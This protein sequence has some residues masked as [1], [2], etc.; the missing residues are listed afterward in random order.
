MTQRHLVDLPMTD[1]RRSKSEL[2]LRNVLDLPFPSDLQ[3]APRG[4]LVAW[5][6]NESGC[7][8]VW[9][10]DAGHIEAVAARR[11]TTYSGDDGRTIGQLRWNR[12]CDAVIYVRGTHL[13][14]G[15]P[16]NPASTPVGAESSEIWLAHLDGEPSRRLGAG[17][18]PEVSH[19]TGDVA[20]IHGT[21]I[22]IA[23]ELGQRQAS[24][25][26]VDRGLCSSLAWSP[27]GTCLAFVSDRG[28]HSL[29]GVHDVA[30]RI[31]RWIAPG[32]DR[33]ILPTW[34]P[35]GKRLAFVRLAESPAPTWRSRPCGI[36][37]SLWIANAHTG[38]AKC[39]WTASEGRGSVFT[40][41]AHGPSLAWTPSGELAF[42]WEGSGWLH[43]HSLAPHAE[44]PIDLTPGAFEVAGIAMQTQAHAIVVAANKDQVDGCRLWRINLESRELTALTSERAVVMAPTVT[45]S[46][47]VVALQAD[48]RTPLH[49]VRIGLAGT[50]HALM[51][52]ALPRDFPCAS[53]VEP[54]A[55]A[56]EAPDGQVIHA[57]LFL[58]RPDGLG[59][60]RPSVVHFHGGPVRQM[61]PAWHH[62][63]T[64]H[65]QYGLNQVLANRGYVV[66]SVNYRGGSGRGL[67]F[68][69]ARQLGAGGASEYQDVIGAARFLRSRPDIDARRIGVYGMSYGGLL[70]ALALARASDLFAAGVDFSGIS[71]WTPAF[72]D[73]PLEV[74]N[75]ASDSSPLG[76]S[77]RWRSPVLFIHADD[78]RVVPFGQTVEMIKTLRERSEAEVECLV[79]PDE[80]HDFLRRESWRRAFDATTD[81]FDRKLGRAD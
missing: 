55:V 2:L 9:V 4:D 42:A 69:E 39:A 17:H 72:A 78:D 36:P 21:Q 22:W 28:T 26:V 53:L 76:L 56:F 29:I 44:A 19:A 38:Q 27:D 7:R 12:A 34:S 75:A 51:T 73:A 47:A 59:L 46:G 68:R 32:I 18:S 80:Q 54:E 61:F 64:Y 13:M 30:Q 41:F 65:L 66:L 10:A 24:R 57:Q 1:S 43:V 45:G 16:P 63:E 35:D 71:N 33:D 67:D 31:V 20:W 79:L 15:T 74:R 25:M 8:N 62:V 60:E 52:S 14:D 49:P 40:P 6:S 50:A 70:T 3:A 58:P 11:L 77:D 5:V 48:A 37:W 81:F 23:D